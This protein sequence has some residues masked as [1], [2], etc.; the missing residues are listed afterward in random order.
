ML[1][2]FSRT[3]L[4]LD[5]AQG[6]SCR[7]SGGTLH[8]GGRCLCGAAVLPH[9]STALLRSGAFPYD[10]SPPRHGSHSLPPPPCR[11]VSPRPRPLCPHGARV[12]R[13]RPASCQPTLPGNPAT[14]SAAPQ[15]AAPAPAQA[16][17]LLFTRAPLSASDCSSL[18]ALQKPCLLPLQP[19]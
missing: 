12:A 8:P 13:P 9:A 6:P 15:R 17:F 2:C 5:R 16:N 19:Q 3:V 18:M 1:R 11:P 10:K 4:G 7:G 14:P